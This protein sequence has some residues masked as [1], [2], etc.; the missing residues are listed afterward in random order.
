VN[1]WVPLSVA[2]ILYI[3]TLF[4]EWQ[5]QLFS[6]SL[7]GQALWRLQLSGNTV[8]ARTEMFKELGE[9]IRDVRQAGDGALLL[10]A[11]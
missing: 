8:V 11:R 5:G 7:A 9:R 3:G 4:S 2:L 1:F 6:G 10:L